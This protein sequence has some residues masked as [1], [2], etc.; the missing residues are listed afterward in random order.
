MQQSNQLHAN[1]DGV[2]CQLFMQLLFDCKQ[3]V[4]QHFI[5]DRDTTNIKNKTNVATKFYHLVISSFEVCIIV[6]Q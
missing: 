1:D 4:E 2:K 5:C 6:S 3:Y